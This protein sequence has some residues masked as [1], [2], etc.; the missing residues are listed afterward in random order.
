[1]LL[2]P[3]YF[4]LFEDLFEGVYYICQKMCIFENAGLELFTDD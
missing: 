3:L 2:I 4:Y 1:M